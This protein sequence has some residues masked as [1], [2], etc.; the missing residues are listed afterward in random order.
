MWRTVLCA[1]STMKIMSLEVAAVAAGGGRWAALAESST[2][3]R[4]RAAQVMRFFRKAREVMS[5]PSRQR[6]GASQA[7]LP[8]RQ[9]ASEKWRQCEP[10]GAWQIDPDALPERAW[11]GDAAWAGYRAAATN[12]P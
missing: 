1:G 10:Q 6:R 3:K 8:S 5:V 4:S 9:D 7:A 12:V 2:A 11:R